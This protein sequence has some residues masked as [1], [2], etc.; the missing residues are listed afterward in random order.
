MA[1]LKALFSGPKLP[2]PQPVARMPDAEDPKAIESRRRKQ[3]E[4]AQGK[5]RASTDLS[6]TYASD[7]LGV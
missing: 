4:L 3:A 1:P 7:S 2:K 5:G 6:G